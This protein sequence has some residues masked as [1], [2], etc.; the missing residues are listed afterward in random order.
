MK[1]ALASAP[2]K[3]RNIEFNIQAMIDAIKNVSNQ[4]DVIVF[5]ESVLQGGHSEILIVEI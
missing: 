5:G 4:A 3:N 1:I 2:V